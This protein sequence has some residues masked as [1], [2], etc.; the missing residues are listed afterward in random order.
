MISRLCLGV[1]VACIVAL[2]IALGLVLGSASKPSELPK[3][4]MKTEKMNIP[5]LP[6][7]GLL[8]HEGMPQNFAMT[9][10]F[11]ELEVCTLWR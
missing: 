7:L 2:A 9:P 11:Y 4:C 10:V 1:G 5:T 6:N 8:K 3:V